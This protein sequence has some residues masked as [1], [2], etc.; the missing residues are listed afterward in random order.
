[1]NVIQLNSIISALP[2]YGGR[3]VEA[4]KPII[5]PSLIVGLV[6][7]PTIEMEPVYAHRTYKC[8][9]HKDIPFTGTPTCR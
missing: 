9:R 7:T 2:V 3:S 8:V 5:S 6:D 1:M 4:V